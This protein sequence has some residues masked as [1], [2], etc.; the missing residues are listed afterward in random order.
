MKCHVGEEALFVDG[1]M[2]KNLT[3]ITPS[4]RNKDE[5]VEINQD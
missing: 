1:Y 2:E 5:V 3:P 4:L